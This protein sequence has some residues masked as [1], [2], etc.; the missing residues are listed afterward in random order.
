MPKSSPLATPPASRAVGTA[1]KSRRSPAPT[2][3]DVARLAG[4]ST[5]AVSKCINGAQRF[6]PEVEARIAEAVK[7]LGYRSNPLAQG[8]TTGRTGNLGIVILDIRNPHFTSFVKGASRAAAESGA[9]LLF[10]DAA[11]STEPELTVLQALHRRVD[12]L[13]VSARLPEPVIEWLVSTGMP[14]VYFGGTPPRGGLHTVGSDNVAAGLLLGRH[15]RDTGHRRVHYVGFG[16]ARWSVERLEGLRRAF[17]GSKSVIR[18]FDVAAPVPEEGER[19]ASQVLLSE[20]PPDAVVTF[21]DLLALGFLSEARTLGFSIPE[22]VSLAGFDNIIY[23]RYVTPA[24]TTVDLQSELMGEQ[25]MRRLVELVRAPD[26]PDAAT[27]QVIPG[28]L[29]VRSSTLAR[30]PG[31][32]GASAASGKP[33]GRG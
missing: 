26:E 27:H 9:N 31:R 33:G 14:V 29:I 24:L 10:A 25:A 32:D 13:V 21:N 5:A 8:M 1:G 11:E 4:V 17:A 23:G 28:R 7:T 20:S 12:G 15:L 3:K 22:R 18:E 30:A 6:T 2:I 16:T 19:I